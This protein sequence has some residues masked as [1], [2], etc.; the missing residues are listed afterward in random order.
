[1]ASNDDKKKTRELLASNSGMKYTEALRQVQAKH[2]TRSGQSQFSEEAIPFSEHFTLW[3]SAE[4]R[5]LVNEVA[6]KGRSLSPEDQSILT[7][8]GTTLGGQ[9]I[10]LDLLNPASKN[11]V[12]CGNAMAGHTTVLRALATNAVSKGW[13]ISR[14]DPKGGE[15]RNIRTASDAV[16]SPRGEGNVAGGVL[17]GD[18]ARAFIENEIVPGTESQ[19]R[20]V[21]IDNGDYA[22]V[23]ELGPREEDGWKAALARL[24]ND[25]NTAVVIQC[26]LPVFRLLPGTVLSGL[27]SRLILGNSPRHAQSVTFGGF[28]PEETLETFDF[29]Q[30]AWTNTKA[31]QGRG[32]LWDGERLQHVHTGNGGNRVPTMNFKPKEPL[33]STKARGHSEAKVVEMGPNEAMDREWKRLVAE[34]IESGA[35]LQGRTFLDIVDRYVHVDPSILNGDVTGEAGDRVWA[36]HCATKSQARQAW[37]FLGSPG[38]EESFIGLLMRLEPNQFIVHDRA[39]H[40]VD[41][42]QIDEPL[43]QRRPLG[44]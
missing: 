18:A 44:E 2:N 13:V 15:Y 8:P 27:R 37:E 12:V 1:M 35:L 36:G 43:P 14:V 42:I 26:T 29:D 11:L 24:V 17:D 32:V 25:R 6:R 4:A 20:L 5:T 30:P 38:D 3:P 31:D 19:P 41:A 23:S 39:Y 10:Y 16:N 7:M 22:F 34:A 9:P 21:V 33:S 28:V 40:W